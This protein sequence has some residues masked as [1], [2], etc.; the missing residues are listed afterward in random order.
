MKTNKNNSNTN[1]KDKDN[2]RDIITE[3][4]KYFNILK[5]KKNLLYS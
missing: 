2:N 5:K 1:E 4:S 3:I